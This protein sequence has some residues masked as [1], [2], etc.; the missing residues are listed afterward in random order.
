VRQPGL[1][2]WTERLFLAIGVICLGWWSS[3][4]V[5]GRYFRSQQVASFEPATAS[6]PARP[7]TRLEVPAPPGPR[8][9]GDRNALIGILDVPRLGVSTPVISGDD[10]RSLDIAA[11]HLPDTP[12]PW[13]PGNSAIAAHRDGLFRP[14]QRVRVGDTIRMRTVNG[15]F[16]YV[17]RDV[18]VVQPSDLSVL[19]PGASD[20]LTLITCYPFTYI[21][22]APKRFVVRAERQMPPAWPPLQAAV[23]ARSVDLT[24]IDWSTAPRRTNVARARAGQQKTITRQVRHERAS[25]GKAAKSKSRAL[26]KADRRQPESITRAAAKGKNANASRRAEQEDGKPKKKKRRWFD[27]FR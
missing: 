5:Y 20:S 15:D 1:G 14:L 24:H 26:K 22:H 3:A 21:G 13:E 6:L 7:L 23:F 10:Q 11:G 18:K 9:Q 4:T 2:L 27:I 17:V 25:A 12:A 16:D 19:A 8:P